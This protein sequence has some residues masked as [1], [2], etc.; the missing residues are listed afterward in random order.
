MS[1]VQ[2][3]APELGQAQR[4]WLDKNLAEQKQRHAAIVGDMEQLTEQRDEWIEEFLER[5]QTRGFNYNCDELRKILKDELP[6]KPD[7][8]F[9]VVY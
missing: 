9:K 5:I 8:P 2:D 7:R 1:K 6:V 4:E 3:E